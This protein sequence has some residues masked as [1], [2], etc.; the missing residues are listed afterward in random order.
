MTQEDLKLLSFSLA[1]C[2]RRPSFCR[3]SVKQFIIRDAKLL[4]LL[5]LWHAKLVHFLEMQWFMQKIQFPGAAQS[6][7][8]MIT[9]ILLWKSQ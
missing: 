3:W 7:L 5:G 6:C 2:R 1:D 8:L 4:S 9:T